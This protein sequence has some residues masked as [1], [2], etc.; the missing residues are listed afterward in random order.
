MDINKYNKISLDTLK[1]KLHKMLENTDGTVTEEIV[2]VSQELDAFIMQ[3][4]K[5]HNY[6]KK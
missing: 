5:K 6:N 3:E 2:K 4:M 1:D